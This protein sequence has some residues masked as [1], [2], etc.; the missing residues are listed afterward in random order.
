MPCFQ[1]LFQKM[2]VGETSMPKYSM[3]VLTRPVEGCEDEYNS[4]Y[5]DIHLTEV[6]GTDGFIAAQRFKLAGGPD[7]PAPYLAIYELESDDF[8]ASFAKLLQR[9][10][11]GKIAISSALDVPTAIAAGYEPITE[12]VTA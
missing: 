1:I 10:E 11:E 3:I 2:P 12:R 6:L 9:V 7:A 5:N 8:A 4:W